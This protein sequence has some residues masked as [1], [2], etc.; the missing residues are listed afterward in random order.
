MTPFL[1]VATEDG[2]EQREI[3]IGDSS[4]LYVVIENGLVEG[5]HV[6]LRE[7]LPG[8]VARRL[9]DKKNMN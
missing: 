2:Y 4:E 5:E 1:W 6:L 8:T 7:P 3:V 9:N